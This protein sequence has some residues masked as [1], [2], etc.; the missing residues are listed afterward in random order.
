M[1]TNRIKNRRDRSAAGFTLIEVLVVIIMI[2]VLF[3]IAAPSWNA[4]MN[5]QRV[6][7]VREQAVLVIREAQNK[8]R[9]TRIP[10]A[11][12]F[13]NS[14]GTIVPRAAIVAR[15]LDL[16]T[17]TIQDFPVDVASIKNWKT[18][19]DGDV[20]AETVDFT[21]TPN[22]GQLLFDGN[23]AVEQAS[24]DRGS[25]SA[26][27]AVRIKPKG[28]SVQTYRCVVVKSLLGSIQLTDG[29]KDTTNCK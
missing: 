20:K 1:K 18:L 12:V 5:R 22:D 10:Q 25:S 17:G 24:I 23:G 16:T 28:A 19:G 7:T 6:N 29:E 27:F 26:L 14:G 3:A 21:T 8:A 11:V 4:L 13:D 2:G 15:S 9:L